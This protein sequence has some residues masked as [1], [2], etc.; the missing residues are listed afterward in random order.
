MREAFASDQLN[1]AATPEFNPEGIR[2]SYR[3]SA[4]ELFATIAAEVDPIGTEIDISGQDPLITKTTKARLI[5]LSD[6]GY[7]IAHRPNRP[8]YGEWEFI[9]FVSPEMVGAA[10][11]KATSSGEGPIPIVDPSVVG[12]LLPKPTIVP[13]PV[14]PPPSA[15]LIYIRNLGYAVVQKLNWSFRRFVPPEETGAA[16]RQAASSGDG[17]IEVVDAS[18]VKDLPTPTVVPIPV[19]PPPQAA[20]Q[21]K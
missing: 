13:L 9:H 20:A 3:K 16:I 2:A 8:L 12:G 14:P 17:P 5:Y 15:R 19:P 7:A 4:E 21:H 6:L 18:V 11:V 10:K 1:D